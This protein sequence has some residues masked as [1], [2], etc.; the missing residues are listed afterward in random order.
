MKAKGLS[1]MEAKEES[2]NAFAIY[3]GFLWILGVW[4]LEKQSTFQTC[5]FAVAIVFQVT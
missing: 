1:S 2:D 5:R 4:P 3:H